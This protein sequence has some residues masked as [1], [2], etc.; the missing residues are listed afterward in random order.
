[1]DELFKQSIVLYIIINEIYSIFYLIV[2]YIG[3][4]YS[5]IEKRILFY[6]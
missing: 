4:N 5:I 6:K 2:K 1:M 3:D